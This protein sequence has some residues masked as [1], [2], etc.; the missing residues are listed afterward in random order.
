MTIIKFP[1]YLHPERKLYLHA[2]RR[3]TEFKA[4]LADLSEA[5]IARM[6]KWHLKRLGPAN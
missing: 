2:G 1:G 6:T 3:Y 5:E 4:L